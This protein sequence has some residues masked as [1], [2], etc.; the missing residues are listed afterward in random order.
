[1]TAEERDQRI[2][3]LGPAVLGIARHRLRA[4]PACASLDDLI[5]AGWLGA[6][7]CVDSFDP[8]RGAGLRTYAKWKI[9]WAIG[10][11]LREIDPLS[12][13]HRAGVRNGEQLK[14]P[15]ARALGDLTTEPADQR[16]G[17]DFAAIDRRLTLVAL[18]RQAAL[19]P[20][21]SEILERHCAGERLV[22]IGRSLGI[23]VSR[24]S[25][26]YKRALTKLRAAA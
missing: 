2:L 13:W 3:S 11:Y 23:G 14:V 25:Q 1:V 8:R 22:A 15:A 16:A 17:E 7:D 6:I 9:N 18:K 4:L 10:D 21:Y 5:A 12:R 26:I 19:S 20:R 24:C